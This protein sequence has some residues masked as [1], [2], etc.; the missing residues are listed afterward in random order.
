MDNQFIIKFKIAIAGL[1]FLAVSSYAQPQPQGKCS[2]KILH[3]SYGF[4]LSGT[5]T[6]ANVQFAITG[7]FVA[8]GNG[9]FAG[10]ALQSVSG[11]IEKAPFT[12]TYTLSGDCLGAAEFVFGSGVK[13]NVA[14][15]PVDDG[16]E[17]LIM[18]GDQGTVET[19]IAKKIFR[20]SED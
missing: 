17:I 5:N 13:A 12:G 1:L 8:D 19:G 7:K 3:G 9:H 14:F 18:D 20:H 15:I 4:T 10:A 6:V 2:T 11:K 16:N